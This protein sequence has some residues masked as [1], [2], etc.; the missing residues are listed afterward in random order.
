MEPQFD[1]ELQQLKNALRQPTFR[2][3]LIGHNRYSLYKD[4]ADWLRATFPERTPVELRLAEKDYRHINDELLTLKPGIVLIPDF[5]WLFKEG[6]ESIC[7]AFNQRRDA[8]ARLDIALICFIEPSE[9]VQVPKKVP[10]WWSLR[11]L[12]LDFHRETPDSTGEFINQELEPSSSLGGQTRE[13]KQ[14]E[15]QRLLRQVETTEPENKAILAALYSQLGSLFFD[16]SNY[17]DANTYWQQS[18]AMRQQ[19][20]DRSGEGTTLNNI[21]QIYYARGDYEKTFAYLEQSLAM[22]QQI[23][24]RSGEGT[25]LN[26]MATLSY[27]RGDYEKTLAYLEQSL[28]IRQQIGDRRGEGTTLNNISQIYDAQGDYEKALVYLE[29]SLAMRQQIGDRSGEGTTLN[30]ISQIYYARGDYE[31][32]L[33]YLEQSLA[34]QQQI[35]DRRGEGTTLNNIGRIYIEQ[36]QVEK[37]IP[38][39]IRAYKLFETIGSPN[40]TITQGHLNKIIAQIG[41]E[42]YNQIVQSIPSDSVYPID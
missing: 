34:I 13:E 8:F 29:Q 22:R 39:L 26:N 27:A 4:I 42:K 12:E 19:I 38:L 30:N 32:A 15:I 21:S 2:F 10:D 9:F 14:A 37:A 40:S 17:D 11:S 28:A 36:Q 6:N 1:D 16:L 35:G 5:G 41:E 33:A 7:V 18:L 3:I 31:K 20:G 24:D 23:G 25:T